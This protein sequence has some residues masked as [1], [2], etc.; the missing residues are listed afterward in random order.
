MA[1]VSGPDEVPVGVVGPAPHL[2]TR[3]WAWLRALG[4]TELAPQVLERSGGAE[5]ER[6]ILLAGHTGTASL[7]THRGVGYATTN[8]DAAVLGILPA[9]ASRTG[10]LLFAGTF[11]QAGGMGKAGAVGAASTIAARRF[12]DA[13]REVAAGRAASAALEDAVLKTHAD[14]RALGVN[15][16]TTFTGGLVMNDRV[17]VA[18][19]GDSAAWHYDAHGRLKHQ[20]AAH[21]LGDE[22]AR[23]TGDP[24]DG[25]IFSNRMTSAAGGAEPPR[26]NVST[27]ALARG[28]SLVFATDGLG[29]VNLLAQK[30]DVAQG[31]RWTRHHSDVTAEQ[32]GAL[33]ARETDVA[34]ATQALVELALHNMENGIGKPDN[35]AVVVVRVGPTR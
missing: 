21:N 28:D 1:R 12:A 29:D 22:I 3:L 18:H 30:T 4:R 6:P 16:A 20:T 7:F 2:A 26:I 17:V 27:W 24:N 19:A 13:A 25:L 23:V 14:V 9:R 32:V 11:D 33:V 35:L 8:E 34:A 5:T 15:A 31:L 10:E